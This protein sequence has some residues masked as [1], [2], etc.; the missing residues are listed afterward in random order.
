VRKVRQNKNILLVWHNRRA[1]WFD[2]SS[3]SKY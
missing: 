3:S 2:F 1:I